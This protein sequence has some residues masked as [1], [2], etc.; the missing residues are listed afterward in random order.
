MTPDENYNE[1]V[2]AFATLLNTMSGSCFTIGAI[3]PIA[4]TMFYRSPGLQP[5]KVLLG[6][7]V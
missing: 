3:A 5:L 1:R 6:G 7:I 4:A 2:K